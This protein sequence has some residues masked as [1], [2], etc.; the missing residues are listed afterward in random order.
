VGQTPCSHVNCGIF[1]NV[2]PPSND[3]VSLARSQG[4]FLLFL[5]SDSC[6][7]DCHH[8]ASGSGCP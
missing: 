1:G 2:F 3:R 8:F 7:G 4:Y 5:L 6:S